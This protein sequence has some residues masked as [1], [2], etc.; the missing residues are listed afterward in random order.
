MKKAGV[1]I[2]QANPALVKDIQSKAQ[3]VIQAWVKDAKDKRN[4]DGAM[5]L[6]EFHEELKRVAAG[7]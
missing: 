7:K 1:Q 2:E 5:V 6:K 3:P 4:I